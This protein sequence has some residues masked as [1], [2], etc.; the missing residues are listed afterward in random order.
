MDIFVNYQSEEKGD[1]TAKKYGIDLSKLTGATGKT[2]ITTYA[3]LYTGKDSA[4][5][6]RHTVLAVF[7]FLHD[8]PELQFETISVINALVRTTTAFL[9]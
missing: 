4:P 8:Q 7:D 3:S 6:A 2:D 1:E 9:D 5:T